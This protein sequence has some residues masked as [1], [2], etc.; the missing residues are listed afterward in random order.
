MI[1]VPLQ[2]KF[3]KLTFRCY[4]LFLSW[5]FFFKKKNKC[6]ELQITILININIIK[7]IGWRVHCSCQ[8]RVL[9]VKFRWCILQCHPTTKL[10]FLRQRWNLLGGFCMFGQCLWGTDLRFD[11]DNLS[12]PFF[13]F[14]LIN[15]CVK[16]FNFSNQ[17]F[18]FV[19]L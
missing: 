13:F 2:T 8:L 7:K 18:N 16:P 17:P 12:F 1:E 19:F 15:S 6:I 5:F 4:Y 3:T 9:P 14:F 10:Q 11:T